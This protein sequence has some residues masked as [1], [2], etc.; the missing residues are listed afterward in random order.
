MVSDFPLWN[1]DGINLSALQNFATIFELVELVGNGTYEQQFFLWSEK[2]M[3]TV[4]KQTVPLQSMKSTGDAETTHSLWEKC[5][6]W[7]E[8]IPEKAVIQRESRV[9]REG[10]CFQREKESSCSKLEQLIFGELHL[11][12]SDP[13]HK[14]SEKTLPV[15]GTHIGT[16][17]AG[18][19]L[20]RLEPHWRSSWRTVCCGRDPMTE[21]KNTP[22]PERTEEDLN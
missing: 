9:Q 8:C 3:R 7:R 18:P 16:V 15:G 12:K 1:L 20:L 17:L 21:Q 10:S 2:R 11:W 19:L 13:C 4:M 6:S 5:S 22:L 14:S